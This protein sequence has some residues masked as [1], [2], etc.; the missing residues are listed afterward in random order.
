MALEMYARQAKNTDAERRASEIRLRAERRTGELLKDLARATPADAG[1][2]SGQAR[3]NASNAA[4]RSAEQPSPYA[5]TLQRTGISRQTAHRRRQGLT[6]RRLTP[7]PA[8]SGGHVADAA[9]CTPES[10]QWRSP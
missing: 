8:D 7:A 3:G 10:M 4:T 9:W 6:H 1:K 2:A 5:E